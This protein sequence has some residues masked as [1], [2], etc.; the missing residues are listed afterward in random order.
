[1]STIILVHGIDQQQR[2]ADGLENE[3][4]P[5]LAGGVR[6]AGF[7]TLAD[8]LWRDRSG[9]GGIET[10]MAFYGHLFLKQGQQGDAPSDFTPEEEVFA[11]ALAEEWLT[12]GAQR[13]ENIKVQQAASRELAYVRGQVGVQ[14]QGVRSVARQVANSLARI[15]WFARLGMGFA[16]RFVIKALAQVTRYLTDDSIRE[17][18]LAT[19]TGLV[20]AETKIVIGHSLGSVVAYEAAQRLTHPLPFLL[21]I[22]SP[23]GLETIIYQRLRPQPPGFPPLVRRWVNVT[24]RNDLVAA[25][26]DLFRMLSGALPANALFEC[27]YTVDNGAEPHRADFY[28]AKMQIGKPVGETLSVGR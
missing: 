22:G 19:V 9:P 7:P 26:P 4:L 27:G 24:D 8:Q 12:R 18:A 16:E 3:W 10:R 2:S 6:V 25:E 5:A 11:E 15:P 17:A 21:T 28:L 23:L 13:S 20:D 14:E 1:M